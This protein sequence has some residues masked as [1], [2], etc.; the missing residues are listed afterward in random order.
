MIYEFS[1]ELLYFLLGGIMVGTISGL[2]PGIGNTIMMLAFFPFLMGQDPINIIVFYIAL[3]STG[4]YTGS[5]S[6]TVLAVP[7]EMS[8]LPAVKEGHRLFVEGKGALAISGAALG[9][10]FGSMFCVLFVF[11]VMGYLSDAFF[12]YSTKFQAGV[13]AFVCLILIFTGSNRWYINLLLG[14][15]GYDLGMVG[16][17]S[18]VEH[19]TWGTFGIP[20]LTQGL[21]LF[22]ILLATYVIPE[23][24]TS[25]KLQAHKIHPGNFQSS[26]VPLLTHFRTLFQNF[27][28]VIR[29]SV[30]GFFAG[31]IP[32]LTTI[33]ASNLSYSI[34][35]WIQKRKKKYQVGN[36]PS[37]ISAET[38]NNAAALSSLLPLLLIGIP[39]TSSE[40]VL[41]EILNISGHF[42]DPENFGELFYIIALCLVGINTIALL[43][44]WPFVRFFNIFYLIKPKILYSGI[45]MLL[46]FLMWHVSSFTNN[47]IYYFLVLGGLLPLGYIFRKYNT[48]P[49]IF[50][51]M[52]QNGL[53]TNYFRLP[54]LI[55]F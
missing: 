28:S 53:E 1:P 10:W 15:I 16:T 52:M 2:L 18:V 5:V 4:Q 17:H 46:I 37:L 3:L 45:G 20:E 6:S 55:E 33:I 54:Y 21:P 43:V 36:L 47:E 32:F 48:I 26:N 22:P 49:L 51:F 14:G 27:F 31:L 24:I 25:Y 13:L 19:V 44:A 7:G 50:V 23:I 39:I 38:A 29:G 8:S 9:S 30:I 35:V 34:E 11:L 12:L 41:S 40:A 42:F